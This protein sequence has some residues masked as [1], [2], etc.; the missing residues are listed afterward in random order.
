MTERI[1]QHNNPIVGANI[2]RLR[3]EQNLRAI[4]VIAKL[5]LLGIDISTGTFCKIESG[6]NNPSVNLLMKLRFISVIIMNFSK[7]TKNTC[8]KAYENKLVIFSK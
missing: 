3:T 6:L 2:K 5:N 7:Q 1:N 8:R 4:D